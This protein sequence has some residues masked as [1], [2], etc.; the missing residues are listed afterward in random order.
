MNDKEFTDALF[1]RMYDLGYRK[2][3]VVKEGVFFYK[4][5][6]LMST[7]TPRIPVSCTCFEDKYQCI[8]IGEYLGIIDWDKVDVDTPIL[9]SLDGE[10]WLCRYFAD[11]KDGI[12]YTWSNGTTSWSVRK[13]EYKDA[14][15]FAKLAEV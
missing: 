10:L 8:D 11:F 1:K 4:E 9:V 13:R 5:D 6:T 7:W 2:A 12:V 3:E 14:W 15:S